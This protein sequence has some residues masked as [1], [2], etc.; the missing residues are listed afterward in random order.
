MPLNATPL[1]HRD[2]QSPLETLPSPFLSA[3]IARLRAE[4]PGTKHVT[5]FNAAGAALPPES[6]LRA[7]THYL[8]KEARLGGYRLWNE[9]AAEIEQFYRRAATLINADPSEIAWAQSATMAWR[10]VFNGLELQSGDEIITTSLEYGSNLLAY[11]QASEQRGCTVRYVPENEFGEVD[12]A[13][14][15]AMIG[16][17]TKLLSITH[18]PSTSGLVQPAAAIGKIARRHGILY[19]LDTCQSL[20]QLP[21]DVAKIGCDMLCATG[22]KF[23]RGPRGTGFL[24]VSQAAMERIR[25]T[26]LGGWGGFQTS[27]ETYAL[28]PGARR[29]EHFERNIGLVLGLSEALRYAQELG[30]ERIWARLQGLGEMIRTGLRT[31]PGVEVHDRGRIQGAIVTF[32]VAQMPAAEV[33]ARLLDEEIVVNRSP[34]S[35]AWNYLHSKGLD[36]ILRASPHYFNTEAEIEQFLHVL[37]AMLT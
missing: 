21:V 29:F 24:Y 36:C 35:G 34:K 7:V 22:R 13:A 23:L 14:L 11:L 28:H 33:V 16:P 4:T 1:N 9:S 3:E 31:I 5:H 19:L 12:L 26:L 2:T 17:Q 37:R 18:T 15:A 6:V 30:P 10:T 25:P 20:G 8:E 27:P 32:T